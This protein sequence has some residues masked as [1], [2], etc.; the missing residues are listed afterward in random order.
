MG[1]RFVVGFRDTEETPTVWLYSHWGGS[2]RVELI[3]DAIGKARPRWNDPGYATRIA[4]SRI[5]GDSWN[6]ELGFGITAGGRDF[7]HPD[8]DDVHVVTWSDRTVVVQTLDG[9][10]DLASFGFEVFLSTVPTG[11]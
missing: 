9:E 11:R 1:D 8:Y 6:E 10:I 2:D 5:V 4:I 7:Y 3:A